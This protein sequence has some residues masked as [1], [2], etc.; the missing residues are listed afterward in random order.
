MRTTMSFSD[1]ATSLKF[2]Y[3]NMS[4][5]IIDDHWLFKIIRECQTENEKHIEHQQLRTQK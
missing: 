2:I 3:R 4:L 5:T 1:D